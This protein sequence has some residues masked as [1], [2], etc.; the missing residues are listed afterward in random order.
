[1]DVV[2]P[3]MRVLASNKRPGGAQSDDPDLRS[4]LRTER[5]T[6]RLHDQ[7]PP[8]LFVNTPIFAAG[9]LVGAVHVRSPLGSEQLR[10]PVI[11]WLLMTVNGGMIVLFMAWVLTRTCP[12]VQADAAGGDPGHG[13]GISR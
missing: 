1:M 12:P 4:A 6:T 9:E 11:F 2:D 10:W 8:L 7:D 5:Q 3:R 13:G